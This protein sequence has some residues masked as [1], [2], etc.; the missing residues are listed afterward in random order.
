MTGQCR[1]AAESA[2]LL[3][4][5]EVNYRAVLV[6]S[7]AAGVWT[8]GVYGRINIPYEYDGNFKTYDKR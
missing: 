6:T 4:I 2:A 5:G 3:D 8:V 7:P 1:V